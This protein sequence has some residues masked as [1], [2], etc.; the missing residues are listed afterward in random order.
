MV[1]ALVVLAALNQKTLSFSTP[2][3][4]VE[5]SRHGNVL[6]LDH[7]N[8]N[9]EKGRHDLLKSFYF[10]FLGCAIDPRKEE[11]LAKGSKTLWAN[12]GSQQ[13][14]LPEGKPAAQVFD[15][16]VTLAYPSVAAVARRYEADAALQRALAGTR[17]SLAAVM[18]SGG[19]KEEEEAGEPAA[20]EVTD[21]WGT[22]FRLVADPGWAL[23]DP[24][25]R[26]PGPASEGH[27]LADLTVHAPAGANFAGIARFYDQVLGAPTLRLGGA[28]EGCCVVAVGPRQ[29]LT[30][31][32]KPGGGA[33]AHEDLRQ[34]EGG[35]GG[36]GVSN[37][38]A[39][40]SLYV[41][42][43]PGAYR[44]A[45]ALGATYVNPRFK[46]RAY[47]LDEAIDQCMFRCL[48]IIDPEDPGAGPILKLEHEVRAVVQ[49]D[50]SKY[51]S[52]P[53]DEVPAACRAAAP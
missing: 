24:R 10:D 39:H 53:F 20:L 47:T 49:R 8:I 35:G 46:R 25:G 52:C 43:L 15:G 16:V 6:I 3:S 38:G 14:H 50:G 34:E 41:A 30:F 4:A 18:P 9:H 21:P 26:Q 48:E 31:R 23:A 37:L 11:N 40:V 42:D 12:I 19:G 44:R 45:A 5:G 17:F 33:V 7:L 2:V 36:G 13:F 28:E 51:K 22:A 29:T 32:A 1:L 27:A